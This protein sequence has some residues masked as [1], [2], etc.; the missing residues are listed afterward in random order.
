MNCAPEGVTQTG[1]TLCGAQPL[2]DDQ[3][4]IAAHRIRRALVYART[5]ERDR[6]GEPRVEMC[7]VPIDPVKAQVQQLAT[8]GGVRYVQWLQN[9]ADEFLRMK[10][11][12]SSE[13]AKSGGPLP[14]QAV[15]EGLRH[16]RAQTDHAAFEAAVR[17]A[18]PAVRIELFG[19]LMT[20]TKA[21][22][23]PNSRACDS[24]ADNLLNWDWIIVRE[25]CAGAMPGKCNRRRPPD[26]V[27]DQLLAAIIEVCR[28]P[29]FAVPR[30]QTAD[31]LAR[32]AC[33]TA[34][35]LRWGVSHRVMCRRI[36]RLTQERETMQEALQ[37]NVF[38][39]V[40]AWLANRYRQF[41]T[42]R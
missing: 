31:A 25:A 8:L 20:H 26:R 16:I 41:D 5:A 33:Q 17:S 21:L 9:I 39:A 18:H 36:Q 10:I 14:R 37:F 4:E 27:G 34:S 7:Y 15:R 30:M 22:A 19:W 6:D 24:L 40:A 28:D 13:P 38:I 2:H 23:P 3:C 12:L 42:V 35:L 32:L 11:K 1:A 29:A